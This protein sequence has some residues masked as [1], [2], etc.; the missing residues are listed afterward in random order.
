MMMFLHSHRFVASA[1]NGIA[2]SWDNA[3]SK[4]S[5]WVGNDPCGEKWPGV[6]C[7]QNRVTSM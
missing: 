4:L 6:Y 1:L 3:K 7:T 2:A 5:E